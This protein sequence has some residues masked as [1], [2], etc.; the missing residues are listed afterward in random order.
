MRA[1]E[2]KAPGG[3]EMLQLTERP[4]PVPGAGEVLIK[5]AAAGVNR[6]DLMQREGRYP[7]PKGAPDLPGLEVSGT[8]SAL[9]EGAPRSASGRLWQT[10]DEV[11][12]LIAG[13]GYA[14]R[15]VAPGVQCLP[16][17]RGM[18]LVDA[19]AVPETYFTVWTNVFDRGRLASGDWLLVHG[20]TSGIGTTAIQLAVARGARVIATAGT[21]DKCR[22]C[23]R[24]GASVAINY[25]TEEFVSAVKDATGGRGV[26]VILDIVGGSYTPKNLDCLARDGR[27]VQ[28][29][30]MGSGHAADATISLRIIMLKRLTITGSTLR[31]RTA[32]E[33]GAIALALEREVWP[34]LE[35]QRVRP[36]VAA[37][38]PLAGAEKAHRRLEAGDVIGKIVLTI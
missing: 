9:G 32:E 23:E 22:A 1:V 8:I 5:V 38:F 37:T 17:P 35:S 27:L 24:L 6:P 3:P 12:A 29:G 2:I 13:G 36:V 19:A 11:C 4:D 34:L 20:G 28:I 18:P 31:I 14:E 7:P 30:L 25:R 33:K 10:G 26:D 16:I 15:C 21:A